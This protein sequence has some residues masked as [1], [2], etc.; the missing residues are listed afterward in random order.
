MTKPGPSVFYTLLLAGTWSC[1]GSLEV[2]DPAPDVLVN[3]QERGSLCVDPHPLKVVWMF[4]T[5]DCLRCS[6][7]PAT[8]RR[9]WMEFGADAFSFEAVHV[10]DAPESGDW[11]QRYFMKERLTPRIHAIGSGR[12]ES[13][14]KGLA[15]PA[16]LVIANGVV[17]GISAGEAQALDA[18]PRLIRSK[19]T[20]ARQ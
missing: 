11:L 5:E 16:L 19:P 13:E 1:S 8:L 17:E 3:C 10:T 7:F 4:R 6:G 12:F 2:G 14:F 15:L 9:M 18:L 20:G